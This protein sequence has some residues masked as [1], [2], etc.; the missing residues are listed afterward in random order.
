MVL[1]CRA[2]CLFAWNFPFFVLKLEPSY[3]RR[4]TIYVDDH[5]ETLPAPAPYL[6]NSPCTDQLWSDVWSRL[7]SAYLTTRSFFASPQPPSL[8]CR[9]TRSRLVFG[10]E[11]EAVGEY[12]ALAAR[13]ELVKLRGKDCERSASGLVGYAVLRGL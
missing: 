8:A 5:D 12:R 9:R 4:S 6:G 10:T 7:L 2:S 13:G 11:G 3:R 1:V